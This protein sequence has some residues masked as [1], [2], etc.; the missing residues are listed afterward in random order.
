MTK[1]GDV[2]VIVLGD[3]MAILFVTE[4]HEDYR[5]V[6]LWLKR[7]SLGFV[8]LVFVYLVYRQGYKRGMLDA[9]EAVQQA[10][11]A[12]SQSQSPDNAS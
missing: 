7:F 2:I 9:F 1:N 12:P 4:L 6:K 10:L 8:V 3:K 11:S 5:K